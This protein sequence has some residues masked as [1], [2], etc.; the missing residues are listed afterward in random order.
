M[1]TNPITDMA[2]QLTTVE[3]DPKA[4]AAAVKACLA[5]MRLA[6]ANEAQ[7]NE[8]AFKA[9]LVLGTNAATVRGLLAASGGNFKEWIEKNFGPEASAKKQVSLQ[10]IY[11]CL[12]ASLAVALFPK[13]QR[14]QYAERFNTIKSL[15]SIRGALERGEDLLALPA[16]EKAKRGAPTKAERAEKATK[17]SA[18]AAA[19]APR[20]E[21]D[22]L[23]DRIRDVERREKI[24]AATQKRLDKQAAEL[25]A[26]AA[27]LDER[28]RVITMRE[29][30]LGKPSEA[31]D[32]TAR[33][34]PAT[35]TTA[36]ASAKELERLRA[37]VRAKA[38]KKAASTPP[39]A[40]TSADQGEGEATAA[41]T[42][43]NAPE[44]TEEVL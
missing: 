40:A 7:G 30:A 29:A 22:D 14:K 11:K 39:A 1:S 27:E 19:P 21:P 16:P 32:V 23:Q 25:E 34:V 42:D 8:D 3:D 9:A 24:N 41:T 33:E 10:W 13:S 4:T 5:E 6:V 35:D 36:D 2:N 26:R 37:K 31:I 20:Q 17:A 12:N 15:A 28:E 18:P 43:E 38:G 44:S